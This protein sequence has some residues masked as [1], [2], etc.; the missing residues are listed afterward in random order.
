MLLLHI[1]N[2]RKLSDIKDDTMTWLEKI[3][4]FLNSDHCPN[5]LKADVE[6][7]KTH[8]DNEPINNEDRQIL[9]GV[10]K[11]WYE[12][13]NDFGKAWLENLQSYIDTN[14]KN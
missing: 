11:T 2:W 1:R 13:P 9:I 10:K 12:Y 7:A 4:F 3:E 6:K 5:F 8:V 14:D